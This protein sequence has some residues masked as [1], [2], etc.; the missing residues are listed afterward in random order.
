MAT[1]ALTF[2]YHQKTHGWTPPSFTGGVDGNGALILSRAMTRH[3]IY[4]S[5]STGG[6]AGWWLAP[7]IS[8]EAATSASF[9]PRVGPALPNRP[10]I[11]PGPLKTL[12][13]GG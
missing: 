13:G 11:G 10:V 3:E 2:V 5:C 6:G 1:W 7:T 8:I 4:F 9:H 12:L